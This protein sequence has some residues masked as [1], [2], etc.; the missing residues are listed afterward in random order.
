[1]Q[2]LTIEDLLGDKQISYPGLHV[3]TYRKAAKSR[4]KK[5]ETLALPLTDSI[6]DDIEEDEDS[7]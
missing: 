6:E 4:G 3:A 5:A 7:E 1:M 2:I